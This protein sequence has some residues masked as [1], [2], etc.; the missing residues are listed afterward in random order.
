MRNKNHISHYVK[1]SLWPTL[2]SNVQKVYMNSVWQIG[3]SSKMNFWNDCWLDQ[4]IE[5]M[6]QILDHLHS[7][8]NSCVVDFIEDNR[9]NLPVAFVKKFPELVNLICKVPL[10]V[11]EAYD[12]LVWTGND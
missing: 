3:D 4:P 9:W 5:N 10:P 6:L 2:K 8:V 1:S 11:F 12:H 7:S